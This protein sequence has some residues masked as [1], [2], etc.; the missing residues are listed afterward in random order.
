M[1]QAATRPPAGDSWYSSSAAAM[2]REYSAA[3]GPASLARMSG[4]ERRLASEYISS[5]AWDAAF[6]SHNEA[7]VHEVQSHD[8]VQRSLV[9]GRGSD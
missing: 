6:C 1:M 3:S 8:A 4:Y 2:P 9:A 7:H 5:E